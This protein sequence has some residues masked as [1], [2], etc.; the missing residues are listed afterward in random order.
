MQIINVVEITDGTLLSIDSFPIL[1]DDDLN[2]Q[3]NEAEQL[4]FRKCVE[5]DVSLLTMNSEEK[6]DLISGSYWSNSGY[7]VM[8]SWSDVK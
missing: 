5:N 7:S 4:F 2:S 8:I 3:V 6:E 1:S